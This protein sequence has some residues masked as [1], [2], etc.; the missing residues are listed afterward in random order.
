MM[1]PVFSVPASSVQC[2][3]RPAVSCLSAYMA[4]PIRGSEIFSVM[5]VRTIFLAARKDWTVML[6]R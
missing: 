1:E 5:L 4:Q 3:R 6:R 2:I